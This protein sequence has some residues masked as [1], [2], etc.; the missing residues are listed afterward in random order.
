MS[1][2]AEIREKYMSAPRDFIEEIQT[3]VGLPIK[4]VQI[5]DDTEAF[6]KLIEGL[7]TYPFEE[8]LFTNP[9]VIFS[10]VENKKGFTLKVHNCL[11]FQLHDGSL[12]RI[13]PTDDDKIELT[14]I[15]TS[16]SG[17]GKGSELMK[18][19]LNYIDSLLGYIPPIQAELT[20]AIGMNTTYKETPISKQKL[21]FQKHG[22]KVTYSSKGFLKMERP[23]SK[24]S[25]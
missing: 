20:G 13:S 21:F 16:E 1:K 2:V 24:K 22:F 19:L 18:F 6:I 8:V 23:E 4:N 14:R 9:F 25:N 12:I 3:N 15:E 17:K 10:L 5:V 11:T 7:N